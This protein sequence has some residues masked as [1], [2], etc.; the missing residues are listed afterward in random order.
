MKDLR[1]HFVKGGEFEDTSEDT[2]ETDEEEMV[3]QDK[4]PI[5]W[6]DVLEARTEF[7]RTSNIQHL[8]N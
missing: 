8:K 7:Q 6:E 5:N 1:E 3:K 2:V 4:A